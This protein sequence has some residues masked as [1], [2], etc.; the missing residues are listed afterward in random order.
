MKIEL[1]KI[2]V[3]ELSDG[4]IDNAECGVMGYYGK[5]DIRPPYQREFIYKDKQRNAVIDTITKGFPL[6]V[7][8]WAVREDGNFEIIDGQQRTISICQYVHS[9]FSVNGLAF[10]NLPNDKKEQILNYEL[11]VYF[12]SGADSEKLDWFRTINIAGEKL[13]DQ[14]LRNAVY[15]GSWV[16]DAKRYFSKN[17]CV[18]VKIGGDY[19]NGTAIRQEYLETAINWISCGKIEDYMSAHQHDPNASALWRYFQDVISWV[20]T[21]FTVYRKEMKGVPW[22]PLYNTYKDEVYDTDAIEKEILKLIDDDEIQNIKGI[23]PYILTREEKYLNLRVFDDKTKRKVYER[24]KGICPRCGNNRHYEF[25]EMEGDHIKPWHEGGK[26]EEINC[27][28]LCKDHN[29]RKSGK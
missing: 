16:S 21:T 27:Q 18:A 2:P 7:M 17:G 14:E 9:D 20:K 19:L 25:H 3:R 11:M 5:L 8:Y 13:T 26:T 29:R 10:H 15:S 23:Y 4:Y 22:G 6:N 1:K 12:C 28:M 24:Q